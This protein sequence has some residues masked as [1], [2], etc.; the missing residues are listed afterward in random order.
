MSAPHG[1][2]GRPPLT[3]ARRA[4]VRL[5]IARAAV[6]LF[7]AQ[8]V[9]A[10]TGEQIGTAAG[11][12]ARK[13]WRYFPNKESCVRPLFSA[14]IDAIVACLRQWRPGEPLGEVFDRE[15]ANRESLL[16]DPDRDTVGAL[17]RLTRTEPDLRAVW[18]QTY[19]EAEPA[20]ARALAERAGLPA[21][22]LR[23]AIQAAMFNAA[24]RAAV[25]HHA[26]R[27]VDEP[28]DPAT[29]R[30]GLTATVRSALAVVAE[31]LA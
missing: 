6:G 26:W 21:D 10:T 3:E 24:L 17:V 31:G 7:V 18:L 13:V 23:P 8:G 14:G 12:S 27:T 25:E 30:D 29:A 28:A 19:D 11:V 5:E 22:A 9:A 16:G 20:F 1:R 2:T 15:L 4:E